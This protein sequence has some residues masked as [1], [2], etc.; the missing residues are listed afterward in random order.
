MAAYSW[1]MAIHNGESWPTLTCRNQQLEKGSPDPVFCGW[2]VAVWVGLLRPLVDVEAWIRSVGMHNVANI[3][4]F[5]ASDKQHLQAFG[6][7]CFSS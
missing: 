2:G 4:A 3:W 5:Q 1:S 6:S 7:I